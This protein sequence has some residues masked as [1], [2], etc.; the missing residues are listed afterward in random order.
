MV[1]IEPA[2][3]ARGFARTRQ[4]DG[5]AK[6]RTQPPQ[7]KAPGRRKALKALTATRAIKDDDEEE[8]M[9]KEATE[10]EKADQ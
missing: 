10:L 7:G 4:A 1:A 6:P 5:A 3:R 2:P 9:A 8:R